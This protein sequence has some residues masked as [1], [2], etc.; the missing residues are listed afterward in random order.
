MSALVLVAYYWTSAASKQN[1]IYLVV[2]FHFIIA[3]EGAV[4]NTGVVL[5]K[6]V[7]VSYSV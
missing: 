5:E 2:P 3:C 6:H 4:C 7:S 1:N